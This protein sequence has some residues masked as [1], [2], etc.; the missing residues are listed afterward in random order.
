MY[1]SYALCSGMLKERSNVLN[2]GVTLN[3][4]TL[5]LDFFRIVLTLLQ[6]SGFFL[7]VLVRIQSTKV[8]P[9]LFYSLP[10]LVLLFDVLII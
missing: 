9:F 4:P 6:F 7:F 2:R 3:F 1:L 5:S 10:F 8:F